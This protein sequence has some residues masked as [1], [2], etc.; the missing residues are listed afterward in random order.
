MVNFQCDTCVFRRLKGRNQVLTSRTDVRVLAYIRR[1]ILDS[2]WSR[3]TGTVNN[4]RNVAK[5]ISSSLRELELP[6]GC[7]D[8]GPTEAH[9]DY[10]YKADIA[11]LFDSQRPEKYT[12]IHKTW[13]SCRKVRTML[14]N[15]ERLARKRTIQRKLIFGYGQQR[16]GNEVMDVVS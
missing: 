16:N 5:H 13:D 6:S 1:A 11:V 8:H 7:E 15:F 10:G 3:S 4:T 14:E 12:E 2:F 9:D